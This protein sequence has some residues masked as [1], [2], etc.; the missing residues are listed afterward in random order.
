MRTL[1]VYAK[2]GRATQVPVELPEGGTVRDAIKRSGLLTQF[3]DIDLDKQRV[4][5]YGK[6]LTLDAV[7]EEGMRI[8]IYRPITADPATIPRRPVPKPAAK[9]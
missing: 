1:V 8:E 9:E 7:V 6:F 2:P 4:G 3:P 5:S